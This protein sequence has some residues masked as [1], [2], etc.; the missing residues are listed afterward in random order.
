M[1]AFG[2]GDDGLQSNVIDLRFFGQFYRFAKSAGGTRS[3]ARF[4]KSFIAH[5]QYS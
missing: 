4:S 5:F 1:K 3:G 2:C